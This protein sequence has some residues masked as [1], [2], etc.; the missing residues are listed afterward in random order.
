MYLCICSQPHTQ[1]HTGAPHVGAGAVGA[2][3]RLARPGGAAFRGAPVAQGTS[4]PGLLFACLLTRAEI[5][6]ILVKM[7]FIS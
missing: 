5:T 7:W 4:D 3:G 1:C 2:S 6:Q